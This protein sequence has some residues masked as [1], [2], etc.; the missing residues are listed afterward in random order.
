LGALGDCFISTSAIII[1]FFFSLFAF[2]ETAAFDSSC[3]IFLAEWLN[4][5]LFTVN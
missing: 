5:E 3:Y 4:S 1:A 2:I